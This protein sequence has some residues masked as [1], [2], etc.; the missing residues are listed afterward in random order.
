MDKDSL[1][2]QIAEAGYNVGFGAKKHFATYDIIEKAPGLIGFLSMAV[3]VFAL[4]IDV[5]ASKHM[6]AIMIIFG[7]AALYISSYNESKNNYDL[8][9]K[10]LTRIFN[11]LHTLY[12]TVKASTKGDWAAELGE[13]KKL[14]SACFAACISKQ[15]LLSN[16]YA[17]YKFFWEMQIG[18]VDE[19]KAFRFFRDKL[20]LSLMIWLGIVLVSLVGV[21]VYVCMGKP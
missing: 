17:H 4:F 10:E 1:L 13:L 21:V 7:I 16:W 12:D 18:W 14:Q 9:G 8:A 11:D 20:P 5:L 3:G 2:K 15:I 6:S 19:Q